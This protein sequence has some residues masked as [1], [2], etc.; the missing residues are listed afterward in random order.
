MP[1][2]VKAAYAGAVAFL[3]SLLAALQAGT[4]VSFSDLGAASW[5]TIAL[6]TLLAIGG[7]LGLQAA[8]ANISTS[9]R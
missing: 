2:Y 7:I 3:S 9:T 4:G 5:I 1:Y 6:G 8:P